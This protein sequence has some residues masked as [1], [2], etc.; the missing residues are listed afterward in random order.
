MALHYQCTRLLAEGMEKV[1]ARHK[2]MGEYA[3]AWAKENFA[4]FCDDKYG[5]NTLTTV[6]NNR[7]I[8]VSAVIKAVQSKHNVLFGNGY[9][10]LKNE[11][12]RVAHMG[13]I[14]LS[15]LKQVLGWIKDEVK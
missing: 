10:K 4:V 12:F 8:D 15:D 1:W 6:K 2:A 13:D 3:R 5:S 9:G 14:T 11:T 7:G